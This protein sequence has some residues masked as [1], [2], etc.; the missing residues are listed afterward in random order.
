LTPHDP[1]LKEVLLTCRFHGTGPSRVL[2]VGVIP[3]STGTGV[4]LSEEVRDAIP[5]AVDE[6][7]RELTRLGCPASP[8]PAAVPASPWWEKPVEAEVETVP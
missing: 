1:C 5:A 7:L 2:L 3:K 6:I 4:G 8:R